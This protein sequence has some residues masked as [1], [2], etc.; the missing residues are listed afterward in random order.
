[1]IQLTK[2]RSRAIALGTWLGLVCFLSMSPTTVSTPARVQYLPHPRDMVQI[3]EGAPFIVPTGKLLVLTA[4]GSGSG[5][6]H[7]ALLINGCEYIPV[8]SEPCADRTSASMIP[9][10]T[11]FAVSEGNDVDV[12]SGS[13]VPDGRAWGYLVD[14]GDDAPGSPQTLRVPY[15]PHPRDMVRVNW[16]EQYVVPAGKLLVITGVMGL[17]IIDS[18]EEVT[19][20][21][22]LGCTDTFIVPLPP[23]LTARAGSVVFGGALGYLADR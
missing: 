6:R 14:S 1:M 10:P 20:S 7:G 21:H 3:R 5:S 23:G 19:A 8:N 18:Y 4:V 13:D 17:V 2:C 15:Q 9:I 12:Y 16:P 22:D 11:G